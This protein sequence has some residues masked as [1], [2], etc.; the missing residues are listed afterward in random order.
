MLFQSRFIFSLAGNKSAMTTTGKGEVS[1]K[2]NPKSNSNKNEAKELQALAF[3][4]PTKKK[5]NKKKPSSAK[6]IQD[7]TQFDAWKQKDEVVRFQPNSDI[8]I[9]VITNLRLYRIN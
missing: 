7:P 6:V 9:T 8:T 5:T 3:G 1:K 2:P 4:G